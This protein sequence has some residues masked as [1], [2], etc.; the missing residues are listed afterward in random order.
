[1]IRWPNNKKQ[2][3]TS[4]K[5]N[6][7]LTVDISNAIIAD[8]WSILITATNTLFTDVTSSSGIHYQ[9]QEMDYV[10]FDKE[11]LLPHKLSQYGPGLAAADIDG[12]GFDDI[13][14]GGTGDYPGEFF[15]QQP[16]GK[17]TTKILPLLTGKDVRRPESRGLLLFDA[18][19]DG[20]PD[21]Y[22]ASG[23]NEFV[24]DTKNYGDQFFINDGK[25]NFSFD[26]SALPKNYTS[27]SCIKATDF[28]NDGD[29]DLFIGGR[30]LPG[31]YPQPV[32]SFIYRNDSKNGIIKFTDVTSE[33]AKDLQNS[34]MVCDAVFT[35][36]DND[37]LVDLIVVGEWMPVTF[38]K[39]INGHFKN[40]TEQSG[41]KNETGWW[42]SII[43]GDFD[44][45]SDIDYI[46]GNLGQ[47]SFFRASKDFPVNIY[48]KDFDNNGTPDAVITV[49][50]KDQNGVKKEYTAFNRDDIITQMP[51]LKKQFLTY[52]AFAG[53]DIHHLFNDEQMKGALVL[54]C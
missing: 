33:V 32:S 51:A 22:S 45:D 49:F 37:G 16:N 41:I 24:A 21:L 1:M 13:Y 35:D 26:S 14:V 7:L 12:N 19:N 30:C 11:R 25:G 17:F 31:K 44:N 36:F 53:A 3:L 23:S 52:K 6:Q 46:V 40:V 20:D 47:N 48:A 27:K 18:D 9:Q 43:A 54:T 50:M 4:V 29:L 2:I 42:N 15:M 5:T 38:F 34:G 10:D 39:N 8:D 28:D